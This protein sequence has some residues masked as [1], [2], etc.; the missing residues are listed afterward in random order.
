VKSLEEDHLV[1]VLPW[2]FVLFVLASSAGCG[3]RSHHPAYVTLANDNQVIGYSVFNSTGTLRAIAGSPFP[4]GVSPFGVVALPS[5][6]FVYVANS[7]E[8][9]ISLFKA[10]STGALSEVT[11]RTN[12]GLRPVSLATDSNGSFL[13][14]GSAGANTVTTF[15]I[16]SA[17]G[18]LTQVGAPISTESPGV[19]KV[20]TSGN[21]LYVGNSNTATISAYS[22]GSSGSLTQ[23]AGSPFPVG[24]GPSSIVFDSSAS[25][26]YV[27]NLGSGTFSEFKVTSNSGFLTPVPGSP[28]T[29]NTAS[30]VI[31]P[32]TP[33]S[34]A[35]DSSG[36]FLYVACFNS[37]NI[38]GYSING[39]GI[40][41]Q[42]SGSPFNATAPSF[43]LLDTSGKFLY[44]G[45]QTDKRISLYTID[46]SNG[47]LQGPAF[48]GTGTAPTGMFITQ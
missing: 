46:T 17:S 44:A 21:F 48:Y 31:T 20:P 33:I 41:T 15:S 16:D 27:A 26:M 37:N 24:N 2:M 23:I 11:P 8:S 28:F 10:S 36:Q 13:F 39:Q 45:D 42:I 7:G 9:T 34:L 22:F 3:S 38:F 35:L 6:Q 25:R 43:L 32:T 30:P 19:L 12:V 47:S 4:T 18:A 1:R 40:P 29:V 14:V 5:R